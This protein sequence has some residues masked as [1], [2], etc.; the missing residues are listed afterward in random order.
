[1]DNENK[2]N[3]AD[4][5]H[6]KNLFWLGL[7]AVILAGAWLRLDQFF[8]QVI[9]DDEWHAVH[10]VLESRPER[11]ALSF[12]HA[13]Y[14]IPLT[15]LYWWE[16]ATFGLSEALMRWPMLIAGIVALAFLPWLT[17]RR[18]SR[19]T[20][21]G[22]AVLL[23]ISP[24]LISYSQKARPY[25]LTV[26]F[27]WLSYW[28]FYRY[29]RTPSGKRLWLGLAYALVA[30]LAVWAH[31]IVA[32]FI[33]APFLTEGLRTFWLERQKRK[34]HF[35][36]LLSLGVPAGLL[37]LA[38]TVPPL[39]HDARSLLGKTHKHQA[40]LDTLVG[41]WHLWTGTT[42]AWL[43][44][45]AFLLAILGLPRLW[46]H[47]PEAR[48][49]LT[50]GALTL[51]LV[52]VTE[53]AW[54]NHSLVVA[55]YL[56]PALPLA[57]LAVIAGFSVLGKTIHPGVAIAL[58]AAFVIAAFFT[59][60]LPDWLRTPNSQKSHTALVFEFR[61]H[62]NGILDYMHQRPVEPFW[63]QLA[64]Q[65]RGS[66]TVAV[67]PFA[68]ESYHW[69]A[70]FWEPASGQRVIPGLLLGLCVDKRHGE[71]PDNRRFR[72]ANVAYLA[73]PDDLKRRGVDYVLWQKPQRFGKSAH[74]THKNL[75]GCEGK[76]RRLYGKPVYEDDKIAVFPA[77]EKT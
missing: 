33:A 40:S 47:F 10:Q 16:A 38:L 4:P 14:S 34:T 77:T 29:C 61:P 36:C 21:L 35:Y 12:G 37:T 42:S 71:V 76:I 26:L 51:I 22:L 3:T 7:G 67:A 69:D 55:R 27:V 20:A 52:L 31:L 39:L 60:P 2:I 9:I 63:H 56:L 73:D 68:F 30:A 13:D 62:K 8:L 46:K 43:A 19:T 15:L 18:I 72:F 58:F 74:M 32:L 11:I 24:L 17:A 41:T 50:G 45:A 53:P 28:L 66:L 48:W 5:S 64:Q 59:S 49:A 57:L 23:A 1:M 75:S 25:A 6:H 44:G 65:P 54:S 70:I